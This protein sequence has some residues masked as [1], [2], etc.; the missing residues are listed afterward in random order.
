MK[1]INNYKDGV[2]WDYYCECE[3]EKFILYSYCVLCCKAHNGDDICVGCRK[4]MAFWLIVALKKEYGILN[5]VNILRLKDVNDFAKSRVFILKE[6]KNEV[7]ILPDRRITVRYSL[8]D[9]NI[10]WL[11]RG[12]DLN[13]GWLWDNIT[14]I[15]A[16]IGSL[17]AKI[18]LIREVFAEWLIADIGTIIEAFIYD[19]V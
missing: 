14:S 17:C 2:H 10:L 13:S 3:C 1:R 8:M 19:N 9:N 12:G 6:P 16:K 5:C 11:W 4:K 15:S 7:V 18:A